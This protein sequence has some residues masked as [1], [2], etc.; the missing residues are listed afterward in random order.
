MAATIKQL[1]K[2]TFA[3]ACSVHS[4]LGGDM[5]GHLG[6]VMA[7]APYFIRTGQPFVAPIHP[8]VQDA[9][10]ANATQ[11]QITAA[12]QLNDKAKEDY[13]HTTRSMKCSNSKC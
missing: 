5:N 10:G 3:N 6:I 7:I 9:H 4:E 11:A 8:G 2:E 12:N 13:V 1:K